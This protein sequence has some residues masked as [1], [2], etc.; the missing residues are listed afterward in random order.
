MWGPRWFCDWCY[1][2]F[3][4]EC[5]DNLCTFFPREKW[6]GWGASHSFSEGWALHPTPQTTA[7]MARAALLG[8]HRLLYTPS[9]LKHILCNSPD[10]DL[11]TNPIT[12]ADKADTFQK[13]KKKKAK[14]NSCFPL[15]AWIAV[16]LPKAT[17]TKPN[18]QIW[19]HICLV[20]SSH[21]VCFYI[22]FS[23]FDLAQHPCKTL[24][25]RRISV[26]NPEPPWIC[27]YF[28]RT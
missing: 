10:N 23:G 28:L 15:K 19:V 18:T 7:N 8:D 6:G 24:K 14:L 27:L 9:M 4:L 2:T 21:R 5:T 12:T 17:H 22:D 25:A 3:K 20:K 26:S 13:K 1:Q 11:K 16:L